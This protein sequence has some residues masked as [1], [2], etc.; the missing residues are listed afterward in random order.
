MMK[1]IKQINGFTRILNGKKVTHPS[2]KRTFDIEINPSKKISYGKGHICPFC[3]ATKDFI[4]KRGHRT[5]QKRTNTQ[6]YYCYWCERRFSLGGDMYR[7]RNDRKII[8]KALLLRQEGYTLRE[9]QNKLNNIVSHTTIL[10]WIKKW[11]KK[12][13]QERKKNMK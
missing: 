8:E 2:Y 11:E 13:N 7:M 3:G 9:I 6:R 5:I 12:I 1:I 4:I 10:R